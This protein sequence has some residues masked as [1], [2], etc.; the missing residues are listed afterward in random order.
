MV[1]NP[2]VV[3]IAWY[4]AVAALIYV[5]GGWLARNPPAD[6][7]WLAVALIT[8][9]TLAGAWMATRSSDGMGV[10]LSLAA[11]MMMVIAV[12]DIFPDV[13]EDAAAQRLPLWIPA[14]AA[15]VGFVV[16]SYVTH[17]GCPHGHDD[18]SHD[19]LGAS[20]GR[21]QVDSR[22]ATP[23]VFGGAGAAVALSTHRLVEGATLA[24][25]PSVAVIAAL[26]VHAASEGLA[27]A[28]LLRAAGTKLT[29]WLLLSAAGPA[30]GVVIATI[31]PLPAAAI[32][33]L[34]AMVGGVLLKTALVGI[35]LAFAKRRSGELRSAHIATAV[36]AA[37]ALGVLTNLTHDHGA[38][39]HPAGEHDDSH[40]AVDHAAEGHH[41]EGVV[42]GHHPVGAAGGHHPVGATAGHLSGTQDSGPLAKEQRPGRG[43]QQRVPDP[44]VAKQPKGARNL[45][46]HPHSHAVH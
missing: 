22:A 10:W 29:P 9:A 27:F 26:F 8:V 33:V 16:L 30:F 24:L 6:G 38:E 21:H 34:M 43:A 3:L 28:V 14:I 36:T 2:Q 35:K 17:K 32:P 39:D 45:E 40:H 1:R 37:I 41:S 20:A 42:G 12:T 11:A 13:V 19:G 44:G 18:N 23:A 5:S 4:A 15:L 7:A 25:T 46:A 31:S